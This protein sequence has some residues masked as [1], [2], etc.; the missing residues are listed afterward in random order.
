MS[1]ITKAFTFLQDTI[2][3]WLRDINNVEERVSNMQQEIGRVSVSTSPFGKGK[4]GSMESTRPGKL[5]PVAEETTPSKPTMPFNQLVNRKRKSPSVTSGRASG[6]TRYRPKTMVVVSY[7]G[8]MQKTF[9]LLVR[10]LATGRNMLRKAKMEAKMAELA[11]IAGSSEDE[12]DDEEDDQEEHIMS[13]ISYRPQM[14]S[15]RMRAAARRGRGGAGGPTPPAELFETTDRTLE[16][17]QELCEKSAHLT[18]RE[19]DC[20]AELKLAHVHLENVLSTAKMEIMKCA[21]S[22]TQPTQTCQD[23]DTSDTSVSTI[24]PS[25]KRHF[26][27]ISAPRPVMEPEAKLEPVTT[28]SNLHAPVATSIKAPKTMDIE[29]DDDDEEDEDIDFVMPPVRFTSRRAARA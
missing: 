10:G 5:D 8:D 9:E 24:E 25:Y 1:D 28:Q 18:L 23:Q 22:Q 17:A 15:L 14:A 16:Q 26:P 13:K 19:G 4:T 11:A 21:A 20:R 12:D 7:D 29:V 6:P 27:S 3:Q 2:P